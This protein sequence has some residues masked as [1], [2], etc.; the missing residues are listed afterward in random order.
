MA[1]NKD[2]TSLGSFSKAFAQARKDLGSEG[3]F[4][5]NGHWYGTKLK[6]E[7]NGRGQYASSSTQDN[8]D[9]SI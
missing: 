2:Y 1:D 9:K 8:K 5:Y 7:V 3:K 4:I 6:S